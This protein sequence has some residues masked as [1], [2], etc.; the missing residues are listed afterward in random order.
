MAPQ[1]IVDQLAK[2]FNNFEG[3]RPRANKRQKVDLKRSAHDLSLAVNLS[4]FKQFKAVSPG[5]KYAKR[6]TA[7]KH[8]CRSV[9]NVSKVKPV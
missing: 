6:G 8:L 7:E 4:N 5:L 3:V 1:A 2:D 9:R